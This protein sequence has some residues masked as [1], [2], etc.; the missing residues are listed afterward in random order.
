[1]KTG[2]KKADRASSIPGGMAAGAGIS[3]LL[4]VI[5]SAIIAYLIGQERLK[6]ESVG[7]WIMTILF[8]S[9]FAGAKTA[10]A[11]VRRQ[12]LMISGMSGILYWAILLCITALFFGGMYDSVVETAA[13]IGAGS[14]CAALLIPPEKKQFRPKVKKGN[15]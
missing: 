8:L 12:R 10:F 5:L 6:W 11:A 1:M 15:R 13:I 7:Y 4:T 9:S 3:M 2:F 14:G